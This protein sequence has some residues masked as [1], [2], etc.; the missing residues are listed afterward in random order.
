MFQWKTITHTVGYQILILFIVFE[1]LLS[2]H[3]L[4]WILPSYTFC[5]FLPNSQFF[6]FPSISGYI[7]PSYHFQLFS[8]RPDWNSLRAKT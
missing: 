2:F 7:P 8:H 6:P 3:K 5:Q 4:D 1:V